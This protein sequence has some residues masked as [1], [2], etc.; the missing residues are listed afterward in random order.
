MGLVC[1][2]SKWPSMSGPSPSLSYRWNDIRRI[3]YDNFAPNT[4][5]MEITDV[6]TAS[7]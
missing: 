4:G 2:S 6:Y 1:V 7:G 5:N 3:F